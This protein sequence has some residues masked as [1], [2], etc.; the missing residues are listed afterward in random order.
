[1]SAMRGTAGKL[2]VHFGML[3]AALAFASWWTSHTILDTAR[4]RRATDAVLENATLRRYVAD[5]I[6]A[7]TTPAVGA[8]TINAATATRSGERALTNRLDAALNRRDIRVKL[9]QFVV[10]AHDRLIGARSQPA[11]LDQ[12]TARTLVAAA[13]PT[14][15]AA[16]LAKVHAVRFDV[17]QA[18]I[19]VK[20]R[21]ALAHR[22][23]LYFLGAIV[24]LALALVT[25]DDRHATVKLI[26]KWLIGIS[27]AHLV[28][29][30]IVPVVLLPAVSTNPWVNLVASVARALTAGIVSG[31]V[32][33][34]VGGVAFLFADHFI[35][36]PAAQTLATEGAAD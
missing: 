22:F 11:V 7:A 19:L 31:L 36:T 5:R 12:T 9:E 25:T 3:L 35:P 10:D 28:V 26:G 15:S 29:L 32:V 6:A 4:T 24:L 23:S 20:G 27:V 18:Q 21:V 14:L 30:W 16:D 1:M 8:T 13:V 17:P 33:L 34:A 2:L